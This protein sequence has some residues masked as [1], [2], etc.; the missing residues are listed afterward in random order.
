M[1]TLKK[2]HAERTARR[3]ARLMRASGMTLP[4]VRMEAALAQAQASDAAT[5]EEA[6]RIARERFEGCKSVTN[7]AREIG[8]S[9]T[10]LF[11]WLERADWLARDAHGNWQANDEAIG[12][13][14]VVR[15]GPA[16]IS[17][18]RITPLGQQRIAR[19]FNDEPG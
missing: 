10:A 13:G 4:T 8:M 7:S 18:P 5:R 1:S 12:L 6:A 9:R 2:G 11:R 15:R 16:S 19:R 14:F 17:W 3:F